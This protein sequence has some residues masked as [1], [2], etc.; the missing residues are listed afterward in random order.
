[1]SGGALEAIDGEFDLV[2]NATSASLS[3]GACGNSLS[4]GNATLAAGALCYDMM[5][6]VE[7]SA[8]LR[9][10]RARG[11]RIADGI[12]MLIE[13]A[14]ESFLLW[15]GVRP[16]TRALIAQQAQPWRASAAVP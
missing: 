14:A 10:A 4:T 11:A 2:V 13:Q 8:F 7:P 15:R 1:M 3:S 6:A 9:E 16:D 5:Y 12:G